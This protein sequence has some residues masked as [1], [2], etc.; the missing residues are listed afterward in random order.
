MTLKEY[1]NQLFEALTELELDPT[2]FKIIDLEKHPK[3][4]AFSMMYKKSMMG[5]LFIRKRSSFHEYKHQFTQFAPKFPTS[6][7]EPM[8]EWLTFEDIIV[9]FK[10][11]VNSDLSKF[12]EEDATA[13]LLELA[14]NNKEKLETIDFGDE[15]SFS[16]EEQEQ[17]KLGMEEARVLLTSNFELNEPQ[18]AIVN[19]RLDYLVAALDRNTKTDWKAIAISAVLGMIVIL[20][21]D[22]DKGQ[23]MWKTFKMV[24]EYR[25]HKV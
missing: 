19:K 15:S 23:S 24:F 6:V 22:K 21:V 9:T 25:P 10:Q 11:W 8:K 4:N 5:F 20:S 16:P 14:L 13:D 1:K 18:L 2:D 17:V 3:G 7:I 12:I